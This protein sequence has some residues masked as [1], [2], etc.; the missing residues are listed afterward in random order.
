MNNIVYPSAR[1]FGSE[2]PINFS[3]DTVVWLTVGALL[4]LAGNETHSVELS[5]TT[6]EQLPSE[7]IWL[8]WQKAKRYKKP[9]DIKNNNLRGE[10]K[11]NFSNKTSNHRSLRKF[12]RGLDA[13]TSK[14]SNCLYNNNSG[15]SSEGLHICYS[16]SFINAGEEKS[17]EWNQK[18]ASS[19]TRRIQV[20]SYPG[21]RS[22]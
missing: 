20:F 14:R 11:V 15:G 9:G 16:I 18:L 17:Q 6:N 1:Y 7:N 19:T 3:V 10:I 2:R 12:R 4:R 13:T 21:S 22:F 5:S 8:V